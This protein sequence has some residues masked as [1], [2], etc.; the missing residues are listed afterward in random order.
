[1][2]IS[3]QLDYMKVVILN[4]RIM[5]SF[6]FSQILFPLTSVLLTYSCPEL[7]LL[8]THTE[9]SSLLIEEVI[10]LLKIKNGY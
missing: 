9:D 3:T 1:M 7:G 8:H 6:C 2:R 5:V 10:S 4:W